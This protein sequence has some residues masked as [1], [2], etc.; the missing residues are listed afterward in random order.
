V[1]L[2]LVN[3]LFLDHGLEI[4]AESWSSLKR[5]ITADPESKPCRA[6]LKTLKKLERELAKLR[7]WIEGGRWGDASLALSGQGGSGGLIEQVRQVILDYQTP[8]PSLPSQPAPLPLLASP[9]ETSSPLVTVLLSSLCRAHVTLNLSKKAAKSCEEVLQ[10]N[11]EDLWG[12]TGRGERLMAEEN[13]EEAVRVL[14]TAFE[15]T[16]RSDRSVRIL[17]FFFTL[18]I[19][20]LLILRET[21][22]RSVAKGSKIAQTI[23]DE[24]RFCN[25]LATSST[26]SQLFLLKF[27]RITTKCL[28]YPETLM[29]RRL[30]ELS[31]LFP[32]DDLSYFS[33]HVV[34]YPSRKATLK[35]HPD[36]GGSESAMQ[37]VNEAYEVLSKPGTSHSDVSL[38]SRSDVESSSLE[39]RA[40]FDQGED[41]NDNTQQQQHPFQQGGGFPPNF[42]QSQDPFG[43][44]SGF[45]FKFN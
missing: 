8:L 29:Q 9:L 28:E 42:F 21:D 5:C 20:S 1:R 30:S 26:R 33:T 4:P 13:W 2:S 17:S 27:N 15:Q 45:K 41:P 12:L 43:G 35:S 11:P 40:R 22:P 23:N 31:K 32:S 38:P 37:S 10:R 3:S 25:P 36:K 19:S 16:G 14:S 7:N 39:L 34:C 6:G 18:Q 44:Q 24:G